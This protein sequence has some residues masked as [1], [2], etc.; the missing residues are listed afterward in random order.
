[1]TDLYV[2]A[3]DSTQS[4]TNP[5]PP[6][7][8]S[9]WKKAGSNKR[10]TRRIH[11]RFI[12]NTIGKPLNTF[13]DSKQLLQVVYDAFKAHR[14]ACE[15][16]Q[17]LHRNISAGNILIDERGR[18]ILIDWDLAKHFKDLQS[19]RNHEITG[20]WQF[21]SS[22]LL[23][24]THTIHTIQDDMESFIY[25]VLYHGLRY[26]ED[27]G[28]WHSSV[29]AILDNI[30]D[31]EHLGPDGIMRG[32]QTKL[33]LFLHPQTVLGHRF[34]FHSEP[35]DIWWN[36][37]HPAVKQWH[38]HLDLELSAKVKRKRTV[39]HPS[40]ALVHL[41]PLPSSPSQLALNTHEHMDVIFKEQLDSSWPVPERSP[42]DAAPFSGT[43]STTARA[44]RSSALVDLAD[45]STG[46]SRKRPRDSQASVGG[47]GQGSGSKRRRGGESGM[48]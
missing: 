30:F 13:R 11:H 18:G 9:K 1:M 15:G 34:Q 26:L 45:G 16:A 32:G 36:W 42:N 7:R 17:V 38:D 48:S 41:K 40:A 29:P 19:A 44:Q 47:S 22:H 46:L 2:P 21:M 4:D 28:H 10:I 5:Y 35:F 24:G 12:V 23:Q 39:T 43:P 27:N 3:P 6:R 14:Q 31:S 25:V 33:F 37:V 20:T 8:E